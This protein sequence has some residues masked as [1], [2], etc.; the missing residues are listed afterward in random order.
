MAETVLNKES[1]W[2][3]LAGTA[4]FGAVAAG[5]PPAGP[6][7]RLAF[8]LVADR[9]SAYVGSYYVSLR[10]EVDALVFAGGIGEGSGRL[11]RAVVESCA[12]LGFEVDGARNSAAA[13]EGAAV[14]REI[15]GGGGGGGS[16]RSVGGRG[17]KVLVCKTDEQ[18][19]MAR[20]AAE[21]PAL[22]VEDGDDGTPEL[23]LLRVKSRDAH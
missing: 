1:G 17:H 10:G 14:V 13:G 18:F 9:V 19:E 4:D 22:W 12:C 23:T 8:D 20:G 7:R 11:R 21:D 15:G 3:A 16:S 5:G 6:A 2:K